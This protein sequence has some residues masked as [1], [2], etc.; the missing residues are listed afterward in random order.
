MFT[1]SLNCNNRIP[2]SLSKVKLFSLG[3]ELSG[4]N[5]LA[6][7]ASPSRIASTG[8]PEISDVALLE[9]VRKVLLC[10]EA[11]PRVAL[12]PLRSSSDT[13]TVSSKSTRTGVPPVSL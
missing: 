12:I 7:K 9:I 8:L 6:G 3:L 4:V 5:L 11:S 2:L 10:D 1:N 13:V